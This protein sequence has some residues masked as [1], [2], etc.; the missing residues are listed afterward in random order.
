MGEYTEKAIDHAQ[1]G[2]SVPF[3]K[4]GGVRRSEELSRRA[5]GHRDEKTRSGQPKWCCLLKRQHTTAE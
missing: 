3:S 1:M 2:S 5:T 4:V